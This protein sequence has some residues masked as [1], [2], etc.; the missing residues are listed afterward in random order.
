MF[1]SRLSLPLT[2]FAVLNIL[3][4]NYEHAFDKTLL[5]SLNELRE[6]HWPWERI[7][8]NNSACSLFYFACTRQF[9]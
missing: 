2:Y 7:A 1:S 9:P 8:Q 3:K 5:E 4:K 6:C